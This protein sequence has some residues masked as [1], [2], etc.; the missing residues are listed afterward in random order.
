MSMQ[1]ESWDTSNIAPLQRQRYIPDDRKVVLDPT[2][3]LPKPMSLNYSHQSTKK[4]RAVS[5]S[6][7]QDVIIPRRPRGVE[8]AS[9][10]N[11]ATATWY[12]TSENDTFLTNA[13]ER[14]ER[15]DRIMLYAKSTAESSYNSSTGLVSPQVL[16]E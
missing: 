8:A 13:I 9:A 1:N 16:H 12:T 10:D 14:A 2:A 11:D 7:S 6:K 3:V 4:V 15:I 5:F